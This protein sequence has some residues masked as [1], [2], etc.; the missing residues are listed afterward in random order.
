LSILLALA[1][2]AALFAGC[3]ADES[4]TARR[5][6]SPANST[7]HTITKAPAGAL[8]PLTK[9][10]FAIYTKGGTYHVKYVGPMAGGGLTTDE[11]YAKDG[12][13]DL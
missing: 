3:G 7:P 11:V 6:T 10:I 4:E 12:I 5:T 8:G 9:A 13:P 2:A 1:L